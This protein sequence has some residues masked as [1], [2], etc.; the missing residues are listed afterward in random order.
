MPIWLYS[1][2][3]STVTI[4]SDQLKT[5]NIIFAEHE[6]LKKKVQLLEQEI[7]NYQVIDLL[8]QEVDSV[9]TIKI[10]N[11]NTQIATLNNKVAKQKKDIKVRNWSIAGLSLCLLVLLL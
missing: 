1:Q 11:L 6:M 5:V 2:T 10:T 7:V 3:T 8:R 4:T 9:Q